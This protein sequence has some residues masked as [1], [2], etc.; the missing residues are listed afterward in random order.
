MI[1][2]LLKIKNE[3]K[4]RTI[5]TQMESVHRAIDTERK[6]PNVMDYH[7]E[8]PVMMKQD[9]SYVTLLLRQFVCHNL[10]EKLI[11]IPT[12]LSSIEKKWLIFQLMCS[13]E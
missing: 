10:S 2:Q 3:E 7:K 9:L 11:H 5:K 12:L 1:K 6:H 8:A 13:L 4:F